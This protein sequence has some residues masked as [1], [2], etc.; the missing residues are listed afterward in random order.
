MID[1]AWSREVGR[2]K[3]YVKITAIDNG[4]LVI[5]AQ[6]HAAMQEMLL[7]RKELI[8]KMNKHFA[9]TLIHNISVRISH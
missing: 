6:S 5:E 4:T 9:S 8:R 1:Y 2:L 7:R 3:D